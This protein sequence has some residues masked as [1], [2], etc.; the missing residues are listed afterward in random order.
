MYCFQMFMKKKQNYLQF[1]AVKEQ[2]S[3]SHYYLN[4]IIFVFAVGMNSQ[5][6]K[7]L[8]YVWC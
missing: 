6:S 4:Y 5:Y 8:L 2:T 3:Y 1:Y 7:C